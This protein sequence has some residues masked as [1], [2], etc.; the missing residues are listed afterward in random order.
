[1]KILTLE[2]IWRDLNEVLHEGDIIH[3]LAENKSNEI[4]KITSEGF[5]VI[6]DRSNPESKLVPK[7]MFEK[8][9][10]HLI[11]QGELSNRKLLNDLNVKRSSYVL[12][13]L[14]KLSYIDFDPKPLRIFLREKQISRP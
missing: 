12:A 8:A 2:K 14:A 13:S 6:T 7:W 11:E 1:M 4:D 9:I 3:T 10:N 5:W